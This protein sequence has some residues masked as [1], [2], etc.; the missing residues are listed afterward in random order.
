MNSQDVNEYFTKKRQE[1]LEELKKNHNCREHSKCIE[2][3]GDIDTYEC[4]ICGKVWKGP[5][6]FDYD[7]A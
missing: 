6:N 3:T 1:R 4:R 2:C 5:C 7:Y